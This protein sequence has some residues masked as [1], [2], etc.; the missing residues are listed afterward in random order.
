MEDAAAA[1]ARVAGR[2]V[3]GRILGNDWTCQG[4][5]G[6]GRDRDCCT[7]RVLMTSESHLVDLLWC[8]D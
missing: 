1:R 6:D 8:I 5:R 2:A 4:E 7:F 3:G